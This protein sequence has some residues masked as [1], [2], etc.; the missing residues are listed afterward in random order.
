MTI[1]NVQ[2]PFLSSTS[3]QVE[4]PEMQE[5]Q[6]AMT[7]QLRS[8]FVSIYET[9][10]G[11]GTYDDPLREAYSTIVN[12]LYDEEF[13]EALFELLTDVR[14]LHQDHLTSGHSPAEADQLVS[15]HVS[16]LTRE[17]EAMVDAMAEQFGNRD[18][19]TIVD[20]EIESFVGEYR[21]GV[22]LE[23]AF[24]NFFGKLIKKVGGAVKKVAG[25]ALQGIKNVALI[26]MFRALKKLVGPFLKNVL[27]KAIGRL[28]EAIQPVARSLAQRFGIA[29]PAPKAAAAEPASASAEP[30]PPDDVNSPVQEPV[31]ADVTELQ[32]MLDNQIAEALLAQDEVELE[33]EV[34]RQVSSLSAPAS[35]VFSELDDARERFISELENLN[36]DE[37]PAP[38]VQNFLP[39]VLPAIRLG[40]RLIGRPRVVNFLAKLVAKPISKLI[41]PQ[42]APGLSRAIV[43]TGF[44][45]LGL[46][47][48]EGQTS[49]LA[50]SAVAA[51][52][53]E[54][55]NRVASLPE[56]ILDDQQ[57]LEGFALEAFEHAAASNLPSLFPQATYRARPDLLEGGVNAGWVMLPLRGR[58]RYK[59]C[60]RTFNVKITPYMAG[61]I[62]SFEGASLSDYLQ[63]QLG[64]PEGD[65]VE[66]EL[67]LF[68]AL[69][70]TTIADIT[71]G[72]SASLG[73][74]S[75]DAA[76]TAQL[77]PLTRE[78]AGVLLGKPTLGRTLPWGANSRNLAAGQRLFYASIPG[79]R[80]RTL[81]GVSGRRNPL[82]RTHVN[83]TLDSVRDEIRVRVFMSE[84]RTQKF[85][86]P[87]RQQ[88]HAGSIAV[89]F[90]GLL[91][92]RLKRI[93][94]GRRR[95]GLRIVK[96]GVPPGP[97]T[98]EVLRS[99]PGI[100]PPAF[101]AKLQQWLVHGFSEFIK[102]QAQRFLSAADEPADGV[103][104]VMTLERPPGLKE[105]GQ[106][107]AEKGASGSSIA[108][109]LKQ[110]SQP[111]V[112]VE[113]FPGHKC[114]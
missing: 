60:T 25:K 68:E 55:L 108:D 82:R 77:H 35:P 93:F 67:H 33:L 47:L 13:D 81:P 89:D 31:G 106:A 22:P 85:T 29:V 50:A 8:P 58:K 12:D 112:R 79:M 92:R 101:V 41:G 113:V 19:S 88:A 98:A 5:A 46:E 104:L 6:I 102:S 27:A 24:E 76:T 9:I 99:L 63:D 34:A 1:G 83:V 32:L 11:E 36:E 21:P 39:A 40:V 45:L 100:V 105:L 49:N 73:L 18:E 57:L 86:V 70:G 78:A 14:N 56:Y 38:Y 4:E 30:T 59:R 17:C 2:V 87:L 74:G 107:L 7:T 51:T 66:A 71:R 64:L 44:K 65:E 96:A 109:S 42:H 16:Q 20:R 110:G 43:D 90:H 80:P 84:V 91:G 26:P 10:E 94:E 97:V 52:V 3:F 69:P 103:T 75:S 95:R 72:E 23:P 37:D 48:P 62:E 54:T 61:E 114:D 15:Q 28:P 53:E 111:N